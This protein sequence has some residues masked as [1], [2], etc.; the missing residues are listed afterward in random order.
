M[1]KIG[2]YPEG[3]HLVKRVIGIEG[4]IITCCDDQGRIAVNGEPLDEEAY[5][6]QG[7]GL[8]RPDDR[9]LRAGRPARCPKGHIFVMGDN[10]GDSAD[11]TVHMCLR[12]RPTARRTRTSTWTWWSARCSCCVW[13]SDRF[14]WIGRPDTFADVP[15]P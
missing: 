15:D 11:S 10:R 5:V 7:R 12:T 1:A 13:P 14:S 4:D 8:Q 3:G 9:Q 6:P 2:L